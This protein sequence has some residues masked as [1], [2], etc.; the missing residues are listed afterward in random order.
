MNHWQCDAE[1]C[2][3]LPLCIPPDTCSTS[4]TSSISISHLA[5]QP[6]GAQGAQGASDLWIHGFH[7]IHGK[8]RSK[9]T[10]PCHS[11]PFSRTKRPSSWWRTKTWSNTLP[12]MT[13]VAG[14]CIKNSGGSFDPKKLSR[15]CGSFEID[16]SKGCIWGRMSQIEQRIYVVQHI[17]VLEYDFPWRICRGDACS[18]ARS[19]YLA[20]RPCHSCLIFSWSCRWGISGTSWVDD[21][22]HVDWEQMERS[23]LAVCGMW[24]QMR[25]MRNQNHRIV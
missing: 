25:R 2:G 23:L 13:S 14:F 7:W 20:L 18:D 21:G 4:S 6:Q 3:T 22:D 15:W 11:M 17:D 8:L 1:S 9:L 5:Q 16:V 10:C 24:T 19:N 12:E